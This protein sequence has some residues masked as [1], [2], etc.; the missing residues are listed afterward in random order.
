MNVAAVGHQCPECVAQGRQTQRSARTAFGG[1]AAGRQGYATKALLGINVLAFLISAIS[2]GRAD[3]VA[4][5]TGLGGLAG[6]VT[7]LTTWGSVLGLALYP[8]GTVHGIAN[9]EYYRL[10][11]AMFLHYG[12]IHLAMNMWALWMLGRQL[13]ADLGPLRFAGLYVLAGLGGNVAVY[14]FSNPAATTVGASTSVFGLFAA[15]FVIFRRLRRDTSAIVPILAINL[16]FTLAVQVH[17][18]YRRVRRARAA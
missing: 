10:L 12:I 5:G 17:R 11:T 9:G 8:D 15:L 14:L 18:G 16:V 1:G 2:A 4:G 13:E 3:A 7:P 6:S